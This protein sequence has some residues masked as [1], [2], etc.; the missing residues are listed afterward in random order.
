MDSS[1]YIKHVAGIAA[2]MD[3]MEINRKKGYEFVHDTDGVIFSVQTSSRFLVGTPPNKKFSKHP[4]FAV[5]RPE[6]YFLGLLHFTRALIREDEAA[7]YLFCP[8]IRGDQFE[9]PD[10]PPFYIQINFNHLD[11][12]KALSQAQHLDCCRFWFDNQQIQ[13]ALKD[14]LWSI[15]L[16]KM[17]QNEPI[18]S[19][20]EKRGAIDFKELM[21]QKISATNVAVNP[22]FQK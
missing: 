12:V 2:L 7:L 10:I 19:D 8:I 17:A 1:Q 5:Q 3:W 6:S 21:K 22:G 4:F 14:H 20:S 11:K 18:I 13:V 16:V 15:P 9:Y